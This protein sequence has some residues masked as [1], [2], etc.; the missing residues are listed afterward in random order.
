MIDWYKKVVFEN[1]AN[2]NGRARRSE[3]W[4]FTLAHVIIVTILTLLDNGLGLTFGSGNSGVLKTIYSL[5]VFIPSLA[6]AVRRLHDVGK[7]GW[8]LLIIYGLLF[9]FVI[10]MFL[11]GLGMGMAG[12]DFSM[13]F[14]IP[15]LGIIA[16]GIWMLILFFTEGDRG[17]NKYG[18]DPKGVGEEINEIGME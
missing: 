11:T 6:V 14:I 12:G 8:L 4:W 17:P 15:L 7:S 3:Y 9:A 5:L 2:F 1:Y 18:P 16:L 13:A 10:A